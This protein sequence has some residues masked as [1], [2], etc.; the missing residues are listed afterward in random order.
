MWFELHPLD[1]ASC[2]PDYVQWMASLKTPVVL[3]EADPRIP[4]SV[5]YPREEM[6]QEFGPYFFTSSIAW[7]LALAIQQKP[8]EI[9]LWGVDMSATEEYSQQRPG[10]HFFI[11]EALKAGITVFVPDQSDLSAPPSQ[12]GFAKGSAMYRK[13]EVRRAELISRRDAE[14]QQYESH[15]NNWHFLNGAIDDIDYMLR[16]WVP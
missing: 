16:T 14:A 13:L 5:R 3:I 2:P 9:G 12:Y 6:V 10:C 15:R 11:R 4:A 1:D 7:M 8:A